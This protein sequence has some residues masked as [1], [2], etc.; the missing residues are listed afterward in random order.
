M[1]VWTEKNIKEFWCNSKASF[2]GDT[3]AKEIVRLSRRYIGNKVLDV[4]AGSGALINLIDNAVGVDIAPRHLRIV[5]GSINHL[6]FCDSLFDTVFATDILEHLPSDILRKGIKEVHRVMKKGGR[7]IMTIPYKEDLAQ[8]LVWCPHCHKE[9][10]RWGHMQVFD[11]FEICQLLKLHDFE[12]VD[13]RILPI[14]LM[15][16]HWLARYFWQIFVRLGVFQANEIFVV[17]SKG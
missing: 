3:N 11:T 8:S 17:A 6:P 12:L 16:E 10:H 7:F 5:E 13:L 1:E 9:F 2:A 4:G 14:S 15:A